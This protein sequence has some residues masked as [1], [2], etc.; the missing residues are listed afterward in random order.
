MTELDILINPKE[1][2]GLKKQIDEFN[3]LI[4]NAIKLVEQGKSKSDYYLTIKKY[5]EEHPI[6]INGDK[7]KLV[8]LNKSDSSTSAEYDIEDE[9]IE[10]NWPDLKYLSYDAIKHE[11]FHHIQYRKILKQLKAKTNLPDDQLK[12]IIVNALIDKRE[13]DADHFDSILGDNA[14]YRELYYITNKEL[15]NFADTIARNL[16]MYMEENKDYTLLYKLE[17]LKRN[18]EYSKLVS[19]KPDLYKGS[20]FYKNLDGRLK[21]LH[22]FLVSKQGESKAS[23]TTQNID[24]KLLNSITDLLHTYIG[25]KSYLDSMKE[26]IA[27]PIRNYQLRKSAQINKQDLNSLTNMLRNLDMRTLQTDLQKYG[28]HEESIT[29]YADFGKDLGL[30]QFKVV[31]VFELIPNDSQKSGEMGYDPANH[32]FYIYYYIPE[33]FAKG[34]LTDFGNMKYTFIHEITH[35]KQIIETAIVAYHYNPDK[36]IEE[37]IELALEE[38]LSKYPNIK[39]LSKDLDKAS[40]ING[41]YKY[42]DDKMEIGADSNA[43][44]Y[45]L[46]N[47]FIALKGEKAFDRFMNSIAVLV[48]NKFK[49]KNLFD[50]IIKELQISDCKLLGKIEAFEEIY[51]KVRKSLINRFFSGLEVNNEDIFKLKCKMISALY[52]IDKNRRKI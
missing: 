23:I 35:I 22:K 20:N 42:L 28:S 49:D 46:Y 40:D 52:Q 6:L 44:Y 29:L 7:I 33:K 15:A 21:D 38:R 24:I 13:G 48:K 5:V 43:S 9:I 16:A 41:L 8:L 45:K 39:E 36:S 12:E 4:K 19:I 34:Q 50:K 51:Y 30:S 37:L 31:I 18:P 3:K 25:N 10:Y 11:L 26:S 2:N 27:T 1:F 32:Q 47:Y 14:T 17:G